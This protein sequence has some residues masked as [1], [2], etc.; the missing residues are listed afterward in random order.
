MD[1]KPDPLKWLSNDLSTV[2]HKEVNHTK[3]N[4]LERVQMI[5]HPW[6]K[7]LCLQQVQQELVQY[8]YLEQG[9]ANT[10]QN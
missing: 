1:T 5:F 3:A 7:E 10:R 4:L 2:T 6:L 8:Q 9:S